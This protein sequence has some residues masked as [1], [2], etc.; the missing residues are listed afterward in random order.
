MASDG[1]PADAGGRSGRPTAARGAAFAAA[2]ESWVAHLRRGGSTPWA[3]WAEGS[4]AAVAAREPGPAPGVPA[5]V[6]ALPGAAQLELLRRLNQ[7]GPLPQLTDHVLERP[8]PGRG[9]VHLALPWP[10]ARPTAPAVEV[11]RVAVGVLADLTVRLAGPDGRTD[12]RDRRGRRPGLRGAAGRSFVLEGPPLTVGALRG[13]L[14]SRGALEHRP[15]VPW[16]S[17]RPRA[18]D[19]PD[20]VVVVATPLDEALHEVWARRVL[21]GSRRSWRG[22]LHTWSA[23]DALPPS[24]DLERILDHWVPT[25]GAGRVHVVVA[26]RGDEERVADRVAQLLGRRPEPL[27]RDGGAPRPVLLDLLRRVDEVLP[28]HLAEDRRTDARLGLARLMVREPHGPRWVGLPRSRRAWAG[29]RGEHLLRTVV[30]SGVTVH[31]VPALLTSLSPSAVGI[32]AVDTVAAAVR[33]I[34]RIEESGGPRTGTTGE[35]TSR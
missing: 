1:G 29:R 16:W 26:A 8:G 2:A 14:A 21:D 7:A 19:V 10:P 6:T 31:G 27:P 22:F 4:A 11:R 17:L 9:W 24:V 34:H 23:R 20:L 32:R 5:Q 15:R 3:D 33:M 28:F 25:A 30:Q 12:G 13:A 35:G 18:G